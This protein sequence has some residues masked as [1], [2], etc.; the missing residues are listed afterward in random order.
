MLVL[1]LLALIS[2]TVS[3]FYYFFSLNE[4]GATVAWRHAASHVFTVKNQIEDFLAD[5][6]KPVRI[7]ASL[8]LDLVRSAL[9]VDIIY[10]LDQNGTT[11]ASSNR[12]AVDSLVG[13][14]F[15]FR[16]Y[17]LALGMTSK[18]RAAYSNYPVYAPP[19]ETP[20]GVVVIKTSIEIMEKDV[21]ISSDE[22]VIL[23]T[24]PSV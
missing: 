19:D 18:K 3:E 7:L 11:I 21:L 2:V 6:L 5:N 10:L 8:L 1:T 16:P 14:N 15:A 4:S 20:V 9:E 17:Y 13:Q 23:L 22:G 12:F 24:G